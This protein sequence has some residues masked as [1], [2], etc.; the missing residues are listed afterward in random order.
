MTPSMVSRALSPNGKVNEQKR[1]LVLKA[2]EKYNFIP[3]RM[4]SRLSGD[5]IKIGVIINTNFK[6]IENEMADGIKEAY[7]ELRD[8][9]LEY[10]LFLPGND[11]K[12]TEAAI[13]KVKNCDAVIISGIHSEYVD[14]LKDI[15]NIVQVQNVNDKIDYLFASEQDLFLASEISA[16]F[17]ADC[18]RFSKRKN[19]ALFTGCLDSSVHAF[20]MESFKKAAAKNGLNIVKC[21]EVMDSEE[22]L[23]A[24]LP[25]TFEGGEIDGAYITS[26]VSL[27]LCKYVKEHGLNIPLVTYDVYKELNEYIKDKTVSATIFQNAKGQAKTAFE[28]LVHYLID[29]EMPPK[30]ILTS[31]HLVMKS[32]LRLYE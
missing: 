6:P 30:R 25:G 29:N 1:Q 23:R 32:N 10:K 2:A 21:S 5:V 26:G 27:S 28:K 19:I 16:E 7:E 15:K 14:M 17:L 20:S 12:R 22:L 4:A 31:V 9:K 11:K 18:L 3:N 13:N 24:A 8:Y